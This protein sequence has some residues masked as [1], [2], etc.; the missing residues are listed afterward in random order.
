MTLTLQLFQG[1]M[2]ET[3]TGALKVYVRT[4]RL[5]AIPHS[6]GWSVAYEFGGR[7][8]ATVRETAEQALDDAS[9]HLFKRGWRRERQGAVELGRKCAAAR[10]GT[11]AAR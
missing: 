7:P 5:R 11:E 10:K 1:A 6:D 8:H 2:R 4:L 9:F 3:P